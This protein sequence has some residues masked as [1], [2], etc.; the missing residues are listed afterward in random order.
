M[1]EGEY[2][3]RLI[4]V[5]LLVNLSDINSLMVR[6]FGFELRLRFDFLLFIVLILIKIVDRVFC[7]VDFVVWN[8]E[9]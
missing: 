6:G 1:K 2:V 7:R 8:L 9:K 4:G 3:I 5:W